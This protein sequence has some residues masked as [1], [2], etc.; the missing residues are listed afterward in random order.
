M[1]VADPDTASVQELDPETTVENP[2]PR[3]WVW[4]E[5]IGQRVVAVAVWTSQFLS[6]VCE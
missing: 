1:V 5:V 3:T 4:V 6:T 2:V